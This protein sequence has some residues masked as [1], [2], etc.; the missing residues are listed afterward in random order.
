V[1]NNDLLDFDTRD[2]LGNASNGQTGPKNRP[3]PG[4]RPLSA[5]S[6][7]IVVRDGKALLTVGGAGGP[8][9]LRGVPQ[10]II[11]TVD[12]GMDVAEAIDAERVFPANVAAAPAVPSDGAVDVLDM[13]GS[14]VDETVK[15]E[16][17]A[18]GHR[19]AG[20]G[21][22]YADVPVLHG[23]GTDFATGEHTAYADTRA[24][25]QGAEVQP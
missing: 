3:A 15:V 16:L 1:L 7:T 12:F 19:L 13:E 24:A 20:E 21:A 8:T 5:M 22:E 9:V 17:R 2:V 18:R 10:A 6:P 23:V 14:R 25:D 11:N 4:K